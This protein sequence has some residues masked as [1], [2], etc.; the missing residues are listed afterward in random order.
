MLPNDFLKVF[1]RR[2]SHLRRQKIIPSSINK[3]GWLPWEQE[4]MRSSET[5]FEITD[6]SLE[7]DWQTNLSFTGFEYSSMAKTV[8][9]VIGYITRNWK[10]R[11]D[12]DHPQLH[13]SLLQILSPLPPNYFSFFWEKTGRGVRAREEVLFRQM[14]YFLPYSS[15]FTALHS[16]HPIQ[17][18]FRATVCVIKASIIHTNSCSWTVGRL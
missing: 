4:W 13:S 15:V 17:K 10:G 3:S 5:I 14:K 11:N 6:N 1:L 2:R 8:H 9:T 12:Q 16:L 18:S 7:W